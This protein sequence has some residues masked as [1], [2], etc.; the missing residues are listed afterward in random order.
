MSCTALGE[1]SA[2]ASVLAHL[3]ASSNPPMLANIST[4]TCE[5]SIHAHTLSYRTRH[6]QSCTR[7]RTNAHIQAHKHAHARTHAPKHVHTQC[8]FAIIAISFVAT[9]I[10]THHANLDARW[11]HGDNDDV[12]TDGTSTVISATPT[13][14]CLLDSTPRT[15]TLAVAAAT[16]A[17]SAGARLHNQ[18]TNHKPKKKPH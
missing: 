18:T 5:S 15:I 3:S 16:A 11:S 12:D 10:V 6:T 4:H 2:L 1:Y 7:E 14:S 9:L 13:H 17:A 8:T